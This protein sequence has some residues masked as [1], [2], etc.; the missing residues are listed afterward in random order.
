MKSESIC[1]GPGKSG[2]QSIEIQLALST[3]EMTAWTS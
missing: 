3:I 1:E 2:I